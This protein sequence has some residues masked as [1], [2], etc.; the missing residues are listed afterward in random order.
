MCKKKQG[1]S[2]DFGVRARVQLSPRQKIA[3]TALHSHNINNQ[4]LHDVCLISIYHYHTLLRGGAAPPK[5]KVRGL[6][7]KGI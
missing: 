5:N 3:G 7:Q 2:I 4:A 6:V 1:K